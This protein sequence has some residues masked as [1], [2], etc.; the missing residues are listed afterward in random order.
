MHALEDPPTSRA[1]S[2]SAFSIGSRQTNFK[3]AHRDVR[4]CR[5]GV[6][7]CACDLRGRT[8]GSRAR[9]AKAVIE[10]NLRAWDRGND[11][12]LRARKGLRARVATRD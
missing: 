10:S 1:L 7:T 2:L 4:C 5:W 9:Y 11:G 12:D 6:C 3:S 8:E